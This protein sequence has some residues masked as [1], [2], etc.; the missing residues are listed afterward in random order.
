MK[1]TETINARS[2]AEI[3]FVGEDLVRGV[4][5]LCWFVNEGGL[6]KYFSF[7]VS[8][9]FAID[10]V[11]SAWAGPPPAE[12]YKEMA[13]APVLRRQSGVQVHQGRGCAWN[14][15]E[16][17]SVL[18][19]RIAILPDPVPMDPFAYPPELEGKAP[20]VT[21]MELACPSHVRREV[22]EE[23]KS[24]WTQFLAHTRPRDAIDG[25]GSGI[26]V[27]GAGA[28][29][30]TV[31]LV[32]LPVVGAHQDGA[33]GLFWGLLTGGLGAT[34]LALGGGVACAAQVVRGVYNTPE[35]I[36]Q[37]YAGKRWDKD[38][39]VWVDAAT[40]LRQEILQVDHRVG[41]RADADLAEDDA[42]RRMEGRRDVV[43]TTFYDVIGVSPSATP[44]EVKQAYFKAALRVHPDKNPGD[45]EA[46]QRFQEL[47]EAY[48][49][50]SDPKL[51]ERYDS[52]G[53]EAVG[54]E[55]PSIDPCLFFSMLFGS[56]QF[57]KYIG[58]LYLAMQTDHFAKDLQRHGDSR[59]REGVDLVCR[60][61]FLKREQFEREVQCAAHL[62]SR[63]DRWVTRR[64]E[65]GFVSASCQEATELV[66]VSFGGRLLRVIGHVYESSAERWLSAL[67]RN[68]GVLSSV[69]EGA[70][71]VQVRANAASSIARSALAVK[72][73]ASAAVPAGGDEEAAREDATREALQSLE[74]SLPVF[75]Q[76]VWDLSVVDIESTLRRVCDKVLLDI[77]VPWQLRQRR[78]FALRR[79]GRIFRDVG[80]VEHS[81]VSKSQVAKQHFEE[82]LHRAMHESAHP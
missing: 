38:Y 62:C 5:G 37:T 66:R 63:L 40:N 45:R 21:T 31:A 33:R 2:R 78:A 60:E 74:E 24:D 6:D 61:L 75:L 57:E 30:G 65:R 20:G 41:E 39:G 44:V 53:Q 48:Q 29:V 82:A 68:V 69:R 71:D 73:A 47:A 67:R 55:V 52:M 22:S 81:D 3:D 43:D 79:L 70:H 64:D 17:G 56:E 7:V 10:G 80:Q 16:F 25:L 54:S 72:R 11:F 50:L 18:T 23:A 32:G 46:H 19:I 27:A 34:V 35:A 15:I 4:A 36:Q 13:C 77:S 8:N 51:R 9:P 26:K 76:T 49:V 12:L 28:L 1:P 42:T 14:I 59:D 58:K